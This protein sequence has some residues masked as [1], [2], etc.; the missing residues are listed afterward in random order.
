MNLKLIQCCKSTMLWDETD[1]V[2]EETAME[3]L[4]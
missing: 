1:N 4:K 2:S 3:Q